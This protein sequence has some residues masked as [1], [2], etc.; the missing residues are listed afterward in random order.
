MTLKE[1]S[2]TISLSA[3][4][5]QWNSLLPQYVN[6]FS[7]HHPGIAV[8]V[9][10]VHTFFSGI[11]DS[12]QKYGFKDNTSMCSTSKCIWADDVH[13]TFAMHQ[14]IA[15][16]LARFLGNSNATVSNSSTSSSDAVQG[17]IIRL[18]AFLATVILT[19]WF[20]WSLSGAPVSS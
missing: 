17:V 9:Y 20:I 4:I 16:D 2:D 7:N 10:D 13:S 1:G 8:G 3:R 14:L 15:A 18:P 19:A 5:T 12:P 11:L 6:A